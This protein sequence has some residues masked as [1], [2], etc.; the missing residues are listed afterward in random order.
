MPIPRVKTQ[1][2]IVESPK[3]RCGD[4]WDKN[5]KVREPFKGVDAFFRNMLS[6]GER[7]QLTARDPDFVEQLEWEWA[8]V[9]KLRGDLAQFLNAAQRKNLDTYLGRAEI[10]LADSKK[11][12]A[13]WK[14]GFST[15]DFGQV[16]TF[17][18]DVN[19]AD[20]GGGFCTIHGPGYKA[21][22]SGEFDCPTQ[23]EI[24]GHN[25]DAE[26]WKVLVEGVV[27]N[28]R[29]SEEVMRKS[30]VLALNRNRVEAGDEMPEPISGPPDLPDEAQESKEEGEGVLEQEG[31]GVLEEPKT[32]KRK[33][34]SALPLVAAAAVGALL[35]L[36]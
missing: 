30:E 16:M 20:I 35:F 23:E 24:V 18:I 2:I 15:K 32:K 22:K 10:Y 34:K 12:Q 21:K 27:K 33:K 6:L 8:R 1:A 25:K 17:P 29:C 11:I 26:K 3:S 28:L 14:V 4:N 9:K 31:E 7:S 19:F 13:S 36:K 5:V